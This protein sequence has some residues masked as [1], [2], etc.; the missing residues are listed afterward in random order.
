MEQ[1]AKIRFLINF[2][3]IAIIGGITIIATRFLLLGMFPFILSFVVAALS[4]KPAYFL[5]K[6]INIK[7][8]ICAV[9]ISAGIYLIIGALLVL[10]VY[11]LIISSSGIIDYI[12][13]IAASFGEFTNSIE[14]WFEKHFS[15]SYN[16]SFSGIL[17]N[18][19]VEL[20]N[21]L[22]DIVKKIMMN[23]PSFILSSIVALVAT[24]YISK[25]YDGLSKFVRS[26]CSK[27]VL[28]KGERI[29]KILYESVLK[30]L[31]GQLILTLITFVGLWLG[32]I[33][34]KINNAYLWAFLI[35]FVDFL[36][37]LGVGI[38]VIP[39][40]IFCAVTGNSALA[41]GLAV[42]YIILALVRNFTE[43]KIVSHQI[44][45]NP[46]FT[47]FSMYLGLKLFGGIGLLLFPII[48]IVTVKYYKEDMN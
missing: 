25:D 28:E 46:L 5:S 24:C 41:I 15:E 48:L 37:V 35:A 43:P 23:A 14:G 38:V 13:E 1:Q 7:K 11:R 4:Q 8:S 30:M 32:F 45:I 36:P 3:Y 42:L 10:L 18:F 33:I 9:V 20:T 44:G 40:A 27:S 16:I 2:F 26:L 31:R 12:P 29:R 47:L 17:E 6:R 22:T 34:L 39:W 21:F 19:T